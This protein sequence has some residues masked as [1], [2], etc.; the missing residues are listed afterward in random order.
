MLGIRHGREPKP[1]HAAWLGSLESGHRAEVGD[2]LSELL[3]E[4][5]VEFLLLQEVGSVERGVEQG[6][7]WARSSFPILL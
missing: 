1:G 3:L 4:A 2:G 7:A 6:C 5:D